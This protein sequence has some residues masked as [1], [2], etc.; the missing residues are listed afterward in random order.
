MPIFYLCRLKAALEHWQRGTVCAHAPRSSDYMTGM[1]VDLHTTAIV[2]WISMYVGYGHLNSEWCS[3]VPM[4][5]SAM[6]FS[7]SLA[8]VCERILL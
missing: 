4:L 5:L 7:M 8:A 1:L 2:V 3:G 6:V